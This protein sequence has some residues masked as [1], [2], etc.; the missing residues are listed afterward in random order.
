MR[1]SSAFTSED[2][3]WRQIVT[4]MDAAAG[5]CD[6]F[7]I[8]E[9]RDFEYS[10]DQFDHL[11]MCNFIDDSA[12]VFPLADLQRG[13]V[14]SWVDW[15]DYM[16]FTARPFGHRPVWIGYDPS[17]TGDSA[18]CS[19]IAPPLVPGAISAFWGATRGAAKTLPSKPPSSRKCAAATTSSTSAST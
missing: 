14:D 9:L 11:L 7:D 3:I 16:P 1:L 8:D 19:V 5:G 13:M 2:K 4:I 18:G 10:P 6:L 15:D 17:L 12:S